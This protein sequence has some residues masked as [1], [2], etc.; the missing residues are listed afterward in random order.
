MIND[1]IYGRDQTKKIVS[2]EVNEDLAEIF[3]E[4][5]G[6][7]KSEFV[8]NKFW[9]LSSTKFNEPL[10]RLEG[11]LHYKYLYQFDTRKDYFNFKRKY[12]NFDLFTIYNTK[13]SHMIHSGMTYF[14]NMVIKDVS[15][16]WFDIETTTLKHTPDAKVLIISNTFRRN[17]KIIRKL[18]AYDEYD[19]QA[20][21]LEVW[22]KWVR[23]INPS[24]ISGHNIT[25]FDLPYIQY[26]ADIN[27]VDMSLG[28]DK[29]NIEFDD[30]ES[31]FRKDGSQF[32][33]YKKI[34]IYGREIIDTFFL[35]IKYDVGRKYET[36]GL[37]QIIK[38]EGLEVKD[39]VFYDASTIKDNYK[40]P[41][42]FKKIKEYAM[43][44]ADDAMS[45]YDLMAA[46]FFYM[47][48]SV[49]KSFQ[50]MIESATGSQINSVMIRS[51]L[52]ENHSIPKADESSSYEGG[53]SIG[54]PGLYRNVKKIDISSLYPSIILQYDVYDK[55]KD[56]KQHFL[57]LMKTFTER[58]LY[59]KKLAKE[60][61][62]KYNDDM[63]SS[64]KIFVNSGYG[65][66]GTGGLQF[67]SPSKAAFIT[68][69]GRSILIQSMQ[70]AKELNYTLANADTDSIS[71]CKSDMSEFSPEEEKQI[72]KD[73]NSLFPEKIRFEDDGLFSDVLILKA[74]NYV[75]KKKGEKPTYKGSAIKATL[76]EKR[77][78]DFIKD[79]IKS[80]VLDKD[81][82]LEVYNN[83]AKEIMTLKSI[84][85]WTTKKTITDKV[86]KSERTN[87]SKVRDAIKDTDFQEGEK[88]QT[89]FRSDNSLGLVKDFNG[90]YSKDKLLDKLY[91]TVVIFEE[92]L[93]IKIFPNYKLK[94]SKVLLEELLN[95][96]KQVLASDNRVSELSNL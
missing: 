23:E 61:K 44:D 46:S 34:H 80:I 13:E 72:L 7:V 1:L 4:E 33:H 93:D 48:Q 75:L 2:I 55:E 41:A 70:W 71:F 28:R 87:E 63:Q 43:F 74:K 26:I 40:N 68:K 30:F 90:D 35:A 49:P 32:Y 56:P 86:L 19:S 29:S 3:T 58:R 9:I 10:S 66:L 96:P 36:Y 50:Q 15:V 54:N 18:F 92:V 78:K 77:L 73:I 37:K 12:K 89:Y 45:L 65:F 53:I 88:I 57:T 79:I 60:T 85:G 6:I 39:R 21:M 81:N 83:Y 82:Y 42:E 22:I 31:K 95:G 24:V 64:L 84:E 14:K 38:Q 51:Y 16:L 69:T 67:N 17:D 11:N 27:E 76:K 8:P 62:E 59:Y 94:R 25:M 47:N 91:K 20:E 5:D 52:Q